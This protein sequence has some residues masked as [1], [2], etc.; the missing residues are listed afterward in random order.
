M[1]AGQQ[2]QQSRGCGRFEVGRVCFETLRPGEVF[3]REARGL[4][5]SVQGPAVSDSMSRATP[6]TPGRAQRRWL[7]WAQISE[8][9]GGASISVG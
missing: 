6:G 3:T 7:F 1:H 8:A 4:S 9:L 2:R 5:L